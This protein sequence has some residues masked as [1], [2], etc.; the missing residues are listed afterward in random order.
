MQMS[1]AQE[2]GKQQT[3]ASRSVA[4][5][6][7]SGQR[8]CV[9]ASRRRSADS[10]MPRCPKLPWSK[11][12]QVPPSLCDQ[13]I[14]EPNPSHKALTRPIRRLIQESKTW[15]AT[16]SNRQLEQRWPSETVCACQQMPGWNRPGALRP[17]T[18]S[19]IRQV[20]VSGDAHAHAHSPLQVICS[21]MSMAKP[22]ID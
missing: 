5:P 12:I 18:R 4:L 7:D 6:D 17:I 15:W 10:T 21:N 14:H 20:V 16:K 11:W 1:C 13:V 22:N 8:M 2:D 3:E 19:V 9:T